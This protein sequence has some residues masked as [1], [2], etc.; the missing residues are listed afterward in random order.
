MMPASAQPG[1]L[2]ADALAGLRVA[3]SASESEDLARLGLVE[4]HFRLALGE[5]ARSVVISGGK[6]AYG[7]HL[8]PDGYTAFLIQELHRYSRRDRP[9]RIYLAWPEHRRFAL[10][11]LH[12][13]QEELGLYGEIVYLDPDGNAIKSD[14]ER[15]AAPSPAVDAALTGKSLTALRQFMAKDSQARILLGGRR[16]GFQGALPGVMEEA[17][18]ALEHK[19]P[20]YLVGGFGGV[21]VDI[22]RAL[23]VDS[24]AWLPTLQGA[25]QDNRL[26]A[27]VA[28]LRAVATA[29]AWHGLSNGL[30]DV[31]NRLLAATPRPSEIA[32]L[33]S[34]GLGRRFLKSS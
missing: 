17:L 14:H 33:V 19:Q 13:Q 21:T 18:V 15:S 28:A 22:V 12:Q 10:E 30:T 26:E 16:A 23:G 8:D 6:L 4:T 2:S 27:G 31:E 3:V 9:L 5:I 11:A 25:V 32:A 1:L 7:G 20:L 24:G 34:L 29:N